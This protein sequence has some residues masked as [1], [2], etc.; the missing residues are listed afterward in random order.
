MYMEAALLSSNINKALE[1]AKLVSTQASNAISFTRKQWQDNEYS[2]TAVTASDL[3]RIEQAIENLN[4]NIQSLQDSVSR[5][6]ASVTDERFVLISGQV[7]DRTL[8]VP[9]G[10]G[11]EIDVVRAISTGNDN[12]HLLGFSIEG[13]AIVIRIVNTHSEGVWL[14]PGVTVSLRRL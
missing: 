1:T 8:S 13:S 9:S 10:D 3:N 6:T 11:F 12:V 4:A 7:T 2:G 5:T 14:Q